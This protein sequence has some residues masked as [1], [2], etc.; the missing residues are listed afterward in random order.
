MRV[1]VISYWVWI[2]ILAALSIYSAR[3]NARCAEAE[4]RLHVLE[5]RT[6]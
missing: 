4:C 5:V 2:V 3:V 1:L 6:Q